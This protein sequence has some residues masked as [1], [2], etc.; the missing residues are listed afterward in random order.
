MGQTNEI[1]RQRTVF[2]CLECHNHN[3]GDYSNEETGGDPK[4]SFK[5][6][7]TDYEDGCYSFDQNSDDP[8]DATPGKD[9]VFKTLV[10][11]NTDDL[12]FSGQKFVRDSI[13]AY[14]SPTTTTTTLSLPDGST[15]D[16]T[17]ITSYTA[18][19]TPCA[20][21]CA[22]QD[23]EENVFPDDLKLA[24]CQRKNYLILITDGQSTIV[25]NNHNTKVCG[26]KMP[27][28]MSDELFTRTR[29]ITQGLGNQEGAVRTFVIGLSTQV[30]GGVARDELNQ[31]AFNGRTDASDDEGGVTIAND[32]SYW[33][34]QDPDKNYAY[35]ATNA[36][37][38]ATALRK[39][40]VAISDV[41]LAVG[42]PVT[43]GDLPFLAD[44]GDRIGVLSS[45]EFP[46]GFGH[47]RAFDLQKAPGDSDFKLWD[48]GEMLQNRDLSSAPRTIY[49]SD[50][51]SF[52]IS[53]G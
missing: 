19:P 43:K 5:V 40:I 6:K 15:E 11:I 37:Q 46:A 48:A 39:V 42:T 32:D 8:D 34:S 26:D 7:N 49:T 13:N 9:P 23:F 10:P 52:Q 28:E 16:I 20:I 53:T 14:L 51:N 21:R 12:D 47:V 25:N 4:P 2:S 1:L 36:Q 35:F 50:P 31:I 22:R 29:T 33:S 27:W 30:L 38:L 3:I 24:N 41:D 18:T 45:S 44:S 17:G